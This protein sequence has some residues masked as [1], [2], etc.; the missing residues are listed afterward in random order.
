MEWRNNNKRTMEL[1]TGKEKLKSRETPTA[2]QQVDIQ[3]HDLTK[4]KNGC[5]SF[6]DSVFIIQDIKELNHFKDKNKLVCNEIFVFTRYVLK[7]VLPSCKKKFV[8]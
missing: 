8:R 6:T 1:L 3:L 2:C 4:K 5:A 7:S